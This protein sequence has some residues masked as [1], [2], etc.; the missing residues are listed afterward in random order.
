M[1]IFILAACVSRPPVLVP[2]AGSVAAVE[3]FGSVS[4]K[5]AEAVLK[6]K[7]AFRFRAPGLGRI[8]ALDPLGRTVFTLFLAGDRA[9]FVLPGERV[10]AEEAPETLMSRLL[11][12]SILPDDMIR[13]LCG[14]WEGPAA[15]RGRD[16][17]WSVETDGQGRVFRGARDDLLFAVREFFKGAG[18]PRDIEFSRPGMTG[19]LRVL[20]LRFDPPGRP[21]PSTRLFSRGTPGKPGTRSRSS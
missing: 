13:L 19:R 4:L 9:S 15:D 20:S 11:G 7:F 8:E 6:G 2:P 5:G 10:Y 3:G 21:R 17:A 18:V 16:G 12:F 1:S 14:T